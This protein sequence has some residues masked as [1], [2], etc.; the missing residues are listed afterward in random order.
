MAI[1]DTMYQFILD[2]HFI[3]HNLTTIMHMLTCILQVSYMHYT[4]ITLCVCY[5]TGSV[6]VD[7][8]AVGA[9][10]SA[11][12][13]NNYLV[14]NSTLINDRAFGD[15]AVKS[16]ISNHYHHND[17]RRLVVVEATTANNQCM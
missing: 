10:C 3:N 14:D 1:G 17:R 16:C 12:E 6:D 7:I 4:P 15:R 5:N 8:E 13:L 9:L 2:Y 11:F